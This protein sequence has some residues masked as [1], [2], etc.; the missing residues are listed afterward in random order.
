MLPAAEAVNEWLGELGLPRSVRIEPLQKDLSTRSYFRLQLD[1][2]GPHGPTLVLCQQDGP[3]GSTMEDFTRIAAQLAEAGIPV[4]HVLARHPGRPWLLQ[5]DAGI[6]DLKTQVMEWTQSGDSDSIEAEYERAIRLLARLQEI[7]LQEPV[8]SRS[9]DFEK[10]FFEMNFFVENAE[11][12]AQ[13]YRVSYFLSFEFRTFLRTVCEKLERSGPRVFAHRDLHSKNV[14]RSESGQVWIDF[15][16]ARTGLP[17]YDLASLL[18]D[19]YVPL[20]RE[21]RMKMLRVYSSASGRSIAENLFYLQ[22]FQRIVKAMGSYLSV[23]VRRP[24][25]DYLE[26]FRQAAM[27]LEEIVQLGG[28]PDHSFLFARSMQESFGRLE[29]S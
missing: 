18:Y 20:S 15:Q 25:P 8:Q 9:F 17:W 5:S 6:K 3:A 4:P 19:P 7:A 27:Y 12:A 13:Q 22:A 2:P 26:A 24:D 16:D 21:F 29:F 14:M 28:F 11:K 1:A 10:L 23:L